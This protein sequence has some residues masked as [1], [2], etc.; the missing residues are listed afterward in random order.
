MRIAGGKYKGRTF[1]PGKSFQAR[2]TTDLAKESLFN[3]L[4]NRIDFSDTKVLDLFAGTGSISYEFLSR[5]CTDITMVEL[6]FKHLQFIKSVLNTINEKASVYRADVFRYLKNCHTQFDLVF[7][8]PPFDH[9]RLAELP[10]FILSKN[11]LAPRGMLIVEHP[12]AFNF[13]KLQGFHELRKYGKVHFSFFLES[14]N[15]TSDL[16]EEN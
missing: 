10:E 5:G 1:N 6:N 12:S 4:N 8:D 7:A 16:L 9:S 13:S 14:E 3:I 15:Q 2:P 11:I